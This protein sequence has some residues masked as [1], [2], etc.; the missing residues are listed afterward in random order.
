MFI[1]VWNV[2][3]G[4]EGVSSIGFLSSLGNVY[5]VVILGI[6]GKYIVLILFEVLN[7]WCE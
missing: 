7:S 1:E 5:L 6:G 2:V 4:V 3:C